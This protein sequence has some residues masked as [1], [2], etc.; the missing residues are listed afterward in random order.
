MRIKGEDIRKLLES[1]TL[2]TH[3]L[4]CIVILPHE[5]RI[6]RLERNEH[7]SPFTRD[8]NI[9]ETVEIHEVIAPW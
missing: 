9:A 3:D 6:Y 5:F 4:R 2:E 8:G 1:Y 7:G